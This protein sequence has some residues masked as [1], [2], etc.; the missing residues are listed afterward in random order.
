MEKIKKLFR[1]QPVLV[2][3]FIAAAATVFIIPP[4]KKYIG[5]LNTT[6]IIQLFSLMLAVAGFR[7]VGVFDHATD[8]MLKKAGTI[9]KLGIVLIVICYFS[10]MLVTNDVALL[11]F[12]PLTLLIYRNINDDKSRILTIVLETAAANLGSMMT[13]VGNPQN[14]YLYNK[15]EL[16]AGS[17]ITTMLPSGL[18]SIVCL[19]GLAFLLPNTKCSSPKTTLNKIPVQQT[20]AYIILFAV[21]LL[22]V[23]R[24]IP[25]YLCLATAI[26]TAVIFD[27]SLLAKVDYVLLAT[28]LCFFVFVG[29]IGRIDAVGDFFGKILS[30]SELWISILLSQFI[31]NVPAAVML[32]EFTDNGTALL[33]GINLGG[34]GTLIAS[35][36]SLIS[37][38]LYRKSEGA[39]SGKYMLT[40]TIISIIMLAVLVPFNL[41]IT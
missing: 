21:C 33:R 18:V 30:G 31:S 20:T 41:I 24:V 4:D 27:K 32:S 15:Y 34:L 17:F 6:V 28:F 2:I 19:I 25:D 8:L 14:L 13:P 7:N 37:F 26:V 40:F 11:T 35:L 3:A 9:R 38:Q 36:A 16:S 39:H 10:S 22:C 1:S 12:V 5:Y 29:N 23:F